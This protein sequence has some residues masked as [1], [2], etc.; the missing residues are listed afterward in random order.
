MRL[1]YLH[2]GYFPLLAGAETMARRVAS[3][4]QQRGHS[5]KIV[6]Q[7][8]GDGFERQELDGVEVIGTPTVDAT[9]LCDHLNWRPDIVHAVDAV[10]PEYPQVA[11]DLARGWGVPF[12][13]TPASTP[14]TWR[15]FDATLA[16][17]READI[18][19]V[20]TQAESAQ[21]KQHRVSADRLWVIGQ[22]PQLVG[23]PDPDK[24]RQTYQISGPMVLFLGRK[25]HSKGYKLVLAA[26]AQV[27][28][29]YPDTHFVFIG[30][31]WDADCLEVFASYADSRIVEIGIVDEIEKYSA[32]VACDL[33][34]LPSTADVF[35]L[36]YVEAW[37]CSKPVIA[38]FFPGIEEIVQHGRD[39][40]IVEADPAAI[41]AAILQLLGDDQERYGMGAAGLARVREQFNW[42]VV[43]DRVE[44]AY[45]RLASSPN[46]F[47][48][49]QVQ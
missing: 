31:R 25:V 49:A 44:A 13:I 8:S 32:L 22:G 15:D 5:V 4:M 23:E 21:F 33:V 29:Q 43:A 11:L 41:A 45:A 46:Q 19:F 37:A 48:K 18:V 2:R 9:L 10:W 12:A 28:S 30:P 35:P 42:Q 38:S 34:C 7:S 20:L 6:C 14:S 39:G 24:F 40:L 16:V 26:A 1:L 3:I 17:C 47:E 36:V 27:W